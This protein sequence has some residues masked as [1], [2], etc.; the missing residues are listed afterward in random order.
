MWMIVTLTCKRV[1][2]YLQMCKLH[3]EYFIYVKVEMTVVQYVLYLRMR[4][5]FKTS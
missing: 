5:I 4:D 3:K 2:V 1:S